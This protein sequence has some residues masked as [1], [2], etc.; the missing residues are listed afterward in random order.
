MRKNVVLKS[1]TLVNFKGIKFLEVNFDEKEASV[2]GANG[3][4]KTTI[5][6]AFTWVLFGKDAKGNSDTK[7]GIKTV[8]RDGK[9]LEQIDHEV[10]AT[11]DVNG[12][13]VELHRIYSEDWV[14]P[15]G[16]AQPILKGHSTSYFYNGVPLKAGDYNTKINEIIEE[17]LFRM[18]T[19]PLYFAGLDWNVQREMLLRI[20]GGVTF[21]EIAENRDDFK[22]LL[23]QL[24]GK[25]LE[26]FKAELS[27]KKKKL[28]E[29]LEQIPTRIDEL[30]RNTPE[31]PDYEA[32]EAEKEKLD[33][34]LEEVDLAMTNAAEAN[35]KYYEKSQD[36]NKQINDL[37][38]EQQ[39]VVFKAKEAE[40]KKV[41]DANST[42]NDA[43]NKHDA[44]KREYDNYVASSG[45]E[46]NDTN[47]N[48]SSIEIDI[49]NL[50]NKIIDKRKEWTK[51]NEEIY[52]SD[53]NGLMCPVY[54]T[55]CSDAS[56]LKLDIEAKGKAK[57]AF[58]E[59]KAADLERIHNEGV[60]LNSQI[61]E[62]QKALADL[63]KQSTARTE[64]ISSK[65]AEYAAELKR[66]STI[67][68]S[69]PIIETSAE[70]K[71]E[72]LPEWD[73][74]ETQIK[75]LDEQVNK[76]PITNTPELTVKK[77]ELAS[78]LDKIKESLSVRTIIEN[79]EKRKE[80]LKKEEREFA[81]QKA[82]LEKQEFVADELKKVRMTEVERRVNQKFKLVRFRMFETQINGGEKPDCVLISNATGAKF[83]DTNNADKINMGLDIID[84]L[85]DFH[86]VSAPIFIDNRESVTEIKET[87]SQIINLIVDATCKSLTIE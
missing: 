14:T 16:S 1:M 66:L 53:E 74:L 47:R 19:N 41:Y 32:L 10:T 68:E 7:F 6:D 56:V 61:A 72:E 18:I 59:T 58:E 22:A 52:Q 38:T 87:G 80:Q 77:K 82:D 70:I 85:C 4:G 28:K 49:V 5:N 8:G 37:R 11:L 67:I 25:D 46:I 40:Q 45:N 34:E 26:E 39:E 42:A 13:T 17:G 20:A 29:A 43:K 48:I 78:Q 71:P 31:A 75:A 36:V 51:K 50:T 69:N 15:R 55:L 60:G 86:G 81:Q 21:E 83:L 9:A 63:R 62:K 76:E 54:K 64:I 12:E 33:K 44:T 23:L 2:F 65:K 73:K 79:N 30:A 3:T 57:Q 35:R 27:A 84:V 24:S